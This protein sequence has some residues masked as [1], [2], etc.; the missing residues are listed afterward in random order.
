MIALFAA[1]AS[2]IATASKCSSVFAQFEISQPVH[3]MRG[4][5]STQEAVATNI[6]LGILQRG[7][8]AV[9]AAVAVG[10]AL[11]VTL[12]SAGNLGGG[13]FMLVHRGETGETV[14]IDYRETAP[15]ASSSG[16]FL[17]AEG[18]VN[19]RRARFSHHSVG[20]PGTVA[21]LLYALERYA[22]GTGILLNNEMDDFSAKP[23]VP[24]A[25]G[26]IG[27]EAN[28]IGPG[29]RP[30]SSMTPV[31]VFKQGAP[32]LA[33]GSLGGSHIITTTLQLIVN[34]IDHGM[35]VAAATA[36]ARIH[37]QWMPDELRVEEGLSEG[38][39]DLLRMRGHHIKV[40]QSIGSTQTV[41]RTHG[42]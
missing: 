6:G 39:L 22:A 1:L 15:A 13:G 11:A 30:L 28:S 5:V 27:G 34:V 38:T 41:V 33:T 42:I 40:K 18:N 3:A 8:N 35:T 37:H 25:Y 12:P 2:A 19:R 31:I 17:D 36:A 23:G 7:G 32:F 14:A 24:N 20:V 21:G 10:F 16:M 4:M 26:L 29:K 9:D